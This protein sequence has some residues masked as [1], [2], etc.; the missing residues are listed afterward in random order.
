MT[1]AMAVAGVALSATTGCLTVPG[2]PTPGDG[3]SP[4]HSPTGR[5]APS[6]RLV[7][8]LVKEAL[9]QLPQ[10][11]TTRGLHDPEDPRRHGTSV[12]TRESGTATD[13]M[14]RTGQQPVPR[15]APLPGTQVQAP[16]AGDDGAGPRRAE[17]GGPGGAGAHRQHGRGQGPGRSG[18]GAGM[19]ELGET[20]GRWDPDS[21]QARICRA[22][23]G[24]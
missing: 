15:P 9:S 13:A 17:G 7:R 2:G 8:P 6:H 21:A 12:G 4:Q 22:T 10:H 23:Y 18:T 3:P 1:K 16:A 11:G 19:C 24:K 14:A 20:Y 5:A